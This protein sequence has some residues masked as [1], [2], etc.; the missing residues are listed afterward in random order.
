MYTTA[1]PNEVGTLEHGTFSLSGGL[2]IDIS[3]LVQAW[4]RG[5]EP[6]HGLVLM[7]PNEDFVH[8][9]DFQETTYGDTILTV[10]YRLQK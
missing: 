9:N 7:G 6:N 2:K 5:E 1:L 10:S 4:M 8:N 3:P